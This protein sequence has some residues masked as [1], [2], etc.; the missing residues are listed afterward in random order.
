VYGGGGGQPPSVATMSFKPSPLMSPTAMP[1]GVVPAEK[2]NGALNGTAACAG[3]ALA[4]APAM[5][6]AAAHHRAALNK[7]FK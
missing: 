5:I 3:A 4:T 6:D 1:L 2:W 7:V